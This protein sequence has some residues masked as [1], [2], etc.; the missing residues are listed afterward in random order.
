MVVWPLLRSRLPGLKWGTHNALAARPGISL[1]SSALLIALLMAD[2]A[3]YV[4][5]LALGNLLG[6]WFVLLA[7]GLLLLA[8]ATP[9]ATC[10]PACLLLCLIASVWYLTPRRVSGQRFDAAY[11]T[12]SR[13]RGQGI[14][15]LDPRY[16]TRNGSYL[17]R[18]HLG[19]LLAMVM[20]PAAL[21]GLLDLLHSRKM[22]LHP[23]CCGAASS[24]PGCF[25]LYGAGQQ[26]QPGPLAAGAGAVGSS[27]P[28]ATPNPGAAGWR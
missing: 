24:L 13:R 18:M 23:G 12:Y 5:T 4:A 16:Y 1:L 19:P 21:A 3:P 10:R 20:L 9:G 22:P 7:L 25:N 14:D 6:I 8:Q 28:G 2:S 15:L 11:G 27:D 17:W 26:A